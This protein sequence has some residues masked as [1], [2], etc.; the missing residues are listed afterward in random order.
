LNPA[1]AEQTV[2]VAPSTKALSLPNPRLDLGQIVRRYR[3]NQAGRSSVHRG[4]DAAQGQ[5]AAG[6]FGT[7]TVVPIPASTEPQA[8]RSPPKGQ[9][10]QSQLAIQRL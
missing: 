10:P 1:E 2:V 9:S 8:I 6:Y 3:R 4:I 5:F 7:A